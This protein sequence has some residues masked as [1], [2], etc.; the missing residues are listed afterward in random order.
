MNVANGQETV[1][2]IPIVV[3]PVE[4]ELALGIV[5]VEVRNVA[6]AIDLA[7]GALYKKPSTPLPTDG[8]AQAVS[9]L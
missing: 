5:P 6:V 4:I 1:V 7:D 3:P 2:R 9:Y 8:F